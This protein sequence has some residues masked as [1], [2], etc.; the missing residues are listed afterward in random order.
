M[1]VT[2]GAS[3]IAA[4]GQ[5]LFKKHVKVFGRNISE[6]TS[7]L[8]ERHVLGGIFLYMLSFGLY[9]FA[10]RGAPG[11]SF[12]YPIF[13]STLIFVVVISKYVLGE[14]MRIARITGILFIILG[15]TMIAATY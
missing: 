8:T 14:S 3:V 13:A 1:L 9:L 4:F 11:I 7:A 2:L 6:I 15:I 12:V 5:Y 10:L